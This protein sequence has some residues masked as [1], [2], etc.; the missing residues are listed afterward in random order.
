MSWQGRIVNTV[1]RRTMKPLMFSGRITRARMGMS[2]WMME[3]SA[4]LIPAPLARYVAVKKPVRGEWVETGDN[5]GRVVL[6][7]HGGAYIAGSPRTHRPLT[8]M[9]ARKAQARVFALDYRQAP[10]HAFPAWLEDAV[11]AYQHLLARGERP[12]QI[13]FAGDSAGG[14]LVLVTLLRLRELG[15]PMPAGAICLSPWSDLACTSR[16]FRQNA[17]VEAMLNAEAIAALGRHH[18][19][20]RDPKDPLLSPAHGNY[21]GLPPLMVHVGSEEILLDDARA[22]RRAAQRARLRLDYREW[23]GMPHVFP[24][25]YSLLPEAREAVA[26]MARFITEVTR[27]RQPG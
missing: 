27:E 19:G 26:D 11:A 8:V 13:V 14:N 15:L 18:I 6:Y 22:V 5:T 25:F 17:G 10:E 21:D 1:L 24:L 2:A 7:F 16:S 20:E 9:L 3:A 4:S 23:P 12:G